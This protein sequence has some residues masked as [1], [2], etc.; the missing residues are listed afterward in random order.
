MHL[1]LHIQILKQSR[2]KPL[3]YLFEGCYFDAIIESAK[4]ENSTTVKNTS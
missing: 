1:K 2:Y 4:S 3:G